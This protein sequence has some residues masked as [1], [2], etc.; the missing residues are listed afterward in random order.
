MPTATLLQI[1]T[2]SQPYNRK[3]RLYHSHIIEKLKYFSSDSLETKHKENYHDI[4]N[5][6]FVKI[7]YYIDKASQ[8]YVISYDLSNN[9]LC[10]N[11]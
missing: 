4:S 10:E 3:S 8:Q 6:V 2:V 7:F 11:D 9:V 5:N 1:M